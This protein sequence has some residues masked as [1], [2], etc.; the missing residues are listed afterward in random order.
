V[1]QLLRNYNMKAPSAT[2][3]MMAL[4]HGIV[5]V[6]LLLMLAVLITDGVVYH[7]LRRSSAQ[8]LW[9]G[10]MT[11]APV[12]VIIFSAVVLSHP[13]VLMLEALSK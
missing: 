4:T 11:L 7:R 5:P 3:L 2:E 9:S 13:L 6:G 8:A 1:E 10:L 12:V